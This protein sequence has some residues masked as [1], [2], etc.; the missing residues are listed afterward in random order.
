[1]QER[2]KV[3][4][5]YENL[6]SP[7]A[8]ALNQAEDLSVGV[9]PQVMGATDRQEEAAPVRA[10]IEKKLYTLIQ[11]WL[12]AEDFNTSITADKTG[13]GKWGNPDITGIK[14]TDSVTQNK[15]VEI[16]TIEAKPSLQQWKQFIFEAISHTRFANTSYYCFAYP[17]NERN[18]L[19]PEIYLYAEEFGLGLLGIEMVQKDYDDFLANRYEP[20]FE[21]V[22]FV[23]L[24][25]PRYKTLR[26]YF[27][28]KF[29]KTLNINNLKELI[30]WGVKPQG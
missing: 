19:D 24:Q 1:M 18:S 26:P 29:F 4:F 20:K 23:E 16:I 9:Q 12:L 10:S 25:T 13:N 7:E 17:E 15:E 21:D 6:E 27:R 11:D 5:Y 2:R 30:L 14:I 3:F 22:Y 28:E 8:E